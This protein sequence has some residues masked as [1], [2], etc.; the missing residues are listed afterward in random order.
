MST[1]YGPRIVT[2]GLILYLDSTIEKSY[3]TISYGPEL[4]TDA[5]VLTFGDGQVKTIFRSSNT[6]IGFGNIAPCVSGK[7]YK[8]VWTVSARRGTTTARLDPSTTPSPQINLPVGTY[9]RTFTCNATGNFS[10]TGNNFGVDFDLDYLSIKEILT[11]NSHLWYDLSGNNRHFNVGGGVSS[12]DKGMLY[13]SANS[14]AY[15]NTVN[16]VPFTDLMTIDIWYK[17]TTYYNVDSA[18]GI[19]GYSLFSKQG[20]FSGPS[21]PLYTGFRAR[22]DSPT[23]TTARLFLNTAGSSTLNI[24]YDNNV[25][26]T[27]Y[28]YTFQQIVNGNTQTLLMY[29]NGVLVASNSITQSYSHPTLV[30][31]LGGNTNHCGNHSVFGHLYS[32]KIYNRILSA[33]EI[34]ENYASKAGGDLSVPSISS[35]SNVFNVT[36]NGT[37]NYVINGEV[38]PTLTLSVGQTYT[39]NIIAVGHPFWIKTTQTT[40]TGDTYNTGVTNNGTADG[41]ITFVVP[42]NAPN[43]LYYNCQLHSSMRGIINI[44]GSSSPPAPPSDPPPNYY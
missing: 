19:N 22:F 44:V 39:F 28:N 2:D 15:E 40:G 3:P 12:S 16:S 32:T 4:V 14:N 1:R 31:N 20:G 30:F 36:N 24:F 41:T 29:V 8:I 23:A 27:L 11:S 35:V 26:N 38:N 10:I 42:S 33:Q 18:C 7:R 43:P 34:K 6:S 37:G 9:S 13:T 17:A 25:I 5:S 21:G